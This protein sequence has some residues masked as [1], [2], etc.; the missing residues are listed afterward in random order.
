MTPIR[1]F[2]KPIISVS[3]LLVIFSVAVLFQNCSPKGLTAGSDSLSAASNAN[4]VL[5]SNS[6]AVGSSVA[7][8]S[9]V[10]TSNAGVSTSDAAGLSIATPGLNACSYTWAIGMYSL[11]TA[12]GSNGLA[13]CNKDNAFTGLEYSPSSPRC[14]GPVENCDPNDPAPIIVPVRI[15]MSNDWKTAKHSF[16][17][18]ENIYIQAFETRV[19][20][21][22]ICVETEGENKNCNDASKYQA[23]NRE[24]SVDVLGFRYYHDG[25][26]WVSSGK[27][28]ANLA[29]KSYRIFWFN[30]ILGIRSYPYNL[31]VL[32][33]PGI[34]EPV[35][36]VVCG[37][38]GG[39]FVA[40][41]CSE[42][43]KSCNQSLVGTTE[44]INC[45]REIV[46]TCS[47]K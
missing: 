41:P 10:T 35:K 1:N 17:V 20:E 21:F 37:W 32:S 39:G 30:K 34:P 13:V 16:Q 9:L 14:I 42:H 40:G 3:I 44:T 29:G 43:R 22:A 27:V 11:R 31:T 47:C 36:V 2:A 33:G 19:G 24:Q 26:H 6:L 25:F 15:S 12:G 18:N 46:S 45:G 28:P 5:S 23:L 38:G 7:S 4:L 8:T